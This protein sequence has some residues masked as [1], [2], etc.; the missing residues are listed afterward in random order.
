MSIDERDFGVIAELVRQRAGIV[1]E[2]SKAY[3]VD[4]RLAPVARRHDLGSIASL[5]ELLR[6]GR[7]TS[8]VDEVVDAMTTNETSFFRDVHPF[9]ALQKQVIPE[10]LERRADRRE[11][12]IWSAA[13]SSGQEPYSIA[14]L[15]RE[16]FA[17][18]LA[19]W[20]VRILATD[21]ST[22][23]L[24]RAQ[25]GCFSQLE[26]NRGLPAG[27]LVRHFT[28]DGTQWRINED[29]RAMVEFRALNLAGPWPVLPSFDIVFL[30]NVLIY[31]DLTTK[32]HVLARVRRTLRPD[33]YLFLGT[34]ETTLNVDPAFQRVPLSGVTCY[35]PA[36]RT[37]A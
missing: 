25:A 19:D 29:V 16:H 14:L 7:T 5:V 26:V 27:M 31:F 33:G 3:L 18:A 34:A 36:E 4:A 11:L 28:R 35:R 21:L 13:C 37:A 30:R 20:S 9:T 8:L 15:L 17:E 10:L 32:Q 24:T 6:R 2:P 1:L 22:D 23:M 12:L